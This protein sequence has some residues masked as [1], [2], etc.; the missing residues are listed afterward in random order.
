M[1]IFSIGLEL[2]ESRETLRCANNSRLE[3]LGKT[4]VE[5]RIGDVK[6]MVEFTVVK[7]M[8]PCVIGGM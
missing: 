2:R 1:K 6:E 3:I 8:N 4:M 7:E 5:V